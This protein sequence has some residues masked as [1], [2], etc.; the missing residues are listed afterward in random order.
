MVFI[1]Q[2]KA[3]D[4]ICNERLVQKLQSAVASSSVDWLQCYRSFRYHVTRIGL[5]ISTPL[6]IKYGSLHLGSSVYNMQVVC[7][8][9]FKAIYLSS[10]SQGLR[11]IEEW[12]CSKRLQINST[13]TNR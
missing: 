8:I 6:L 7:I 3:F 13:K 2:C 11:H 1:D 9:L 4:S 5:S 12:R 10:L